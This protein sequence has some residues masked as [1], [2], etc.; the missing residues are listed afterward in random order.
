MDNFLKILLS[1]LPILLAA[2]GTSL[3]AQMLFEFKK[4]KKKSND[5]IF[6]SLDQKFDAELIKDKSDIQLI[7]NSFSRAEDEIYTIAPVLEDYYTKR[8]SKSDSIEVDELNKRYQ[9][10]KGIIKEENKDKPFSGVPD[11]ERILLIS[12][13]DALKNDDKQAIDFNV[14]ELNSVLTTRNKVYEKTNRLNKWSV[15]LAIVGTFFTILFGVLSL[16]P[17][18]VDYEKIS[19]DN[20]EIIKEQF[21]CFKN[22]IDTLSNILYK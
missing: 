20:K 11:E 7:I 22:E 16:T 1:I 9:L 18:K 10:L 21:E 14:N 4:V 15:P 6:N 3:A 8:L 13:K 5:S 2:L 12:I 17:Q 19:S